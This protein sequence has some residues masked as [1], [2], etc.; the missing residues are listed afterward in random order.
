MAQGR[1]ASA[2]W[3]VL[4]SAI[5]VATI[6]GIVWRMSGGA[7]SVRHLV[8]KPV[9][10]V[11]DGN[12]DSVVDLSKGTY[13]LVYSSGTLTKQERVPKADIQVRGGPVDDIRSLKVRNNPSDAKVILAY[14]Y[15]YSYPTTSSPYGPST[16]APTT[17]P[18]GPG[19]GPT[20][21]PYSTAPYSTVPYTSSP[22][23][24]RLAGRAEIAVFD[25]PAAGEYRISGTVS[26]RVPGRASPIPRAR[27]SPTT[28][29]SATRARRSS[30]G[31]SGSSE[32]SGPRS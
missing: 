10:Y 4:A 20:T 17:G 13:S 6:G 27:S 25:V 3:Y 23:T 16:T 11:D 12:V 32:G 19:T 30:V 22:Y 5:G 21:D 26:A 28:S 29:G 2:W 1:G 14:D 18:L 8:P 24:S 31:R 15:S 7:D 9:S